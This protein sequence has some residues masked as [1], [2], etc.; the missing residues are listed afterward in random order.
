MIKL[1]MMMRKLIWRFRQQA[2]PA[3]TVFGWPT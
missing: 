2:S 3:A 1:R